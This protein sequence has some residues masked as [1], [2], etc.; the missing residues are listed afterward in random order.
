M[1]DPRYPIGKFEWPKSPLTGD[2]RA[3]CL[4]HL[5]AL[6]ARVR[7]W[8]GAAPAGALDKPYREGGWTARQVIHHLADSHLNSYTRFRLALTEARPTIKPYDE[9]AWAELPDA[10]A[11]PVELSTALLDGLHARLDLLLQGLTAEQWAQEFVHP[12]HGRALRLDATL[13]LYA[14]HS[15]HHL[16]H[17]ASI[18]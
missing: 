8:V 12:E 9:S 13:A 10:K 14:W 18:A 17:L 7:A 5:A 15:R 16:A 2:E 3:S 11:A 4:E 1:S 6:P